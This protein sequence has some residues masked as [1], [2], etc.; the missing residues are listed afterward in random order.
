MG[1]SERLTLAL[2]LIFSCL[3]A[4]SQKTLK[5]ERKA[6]KTFYEEQF[7]KAL[8]LYQQI[9]SIDSDHSNA[10]YRLELCS[11]LI[12][13]YRTKPLNT[14]LDY[15]STQGRKDKFYNYWLGRA[16][17]TRYRYEEAIASWNAFL[18]LTV[19][20]SKIIIDETKALIEVAKN[21]NQSSQ[22]PVLFDVQKLDDHIN[23]SNSELSPTLL[24]AYNQMIF[25]SRNRS[26][27]SLKL[28]I[29][30]MSES[31]WNKPLVFDGFG[32]L[33]NENIDIDYLEPGKLF[34]KNDSKRISVITNVD[35]VWTKEPDDIKLPGGKAKSHF[36]INQDED[37]MVFAQMDYSN[38]LDLYETVKTD[39]KWSAP[40]FMVNLNTEFNEDSPFLSRDGKTLYF[41]SEG[42]D[43]VG[44][45][46][47]MVSTF[48]G[49]EWSEPQN[50]G[51]PL[52]T[53]DDELHYSSSKDG[54]YGYFSSNRLNGNGGFDIYMFKEVPFTEIEG[55]IVNANNNVFV[56]GLRI[57]FQPEKYLNQNFSNFTSNVG[58]YEMEIISSEDY[59]VR[60]FENEN[61]LLDEKLIITPEELS[62]SQI[63]RDFKVIPEGGVSLADAL[64]TNENADFN[65]D[66]Y[67]E[68][69]FIAN[70]FR[71][72]RKAMLNNLYFKSGTSELIEDSKGALDILFKVMSDNQELKVMIAGHT[73][74]KGNG[75]YNLQL[76]DERAR[77]IANEIAQKGIAPH[78][79]T[80]VGH[81]ET[82]P[83]ASNDDEKDGRALNRR[84]EVIVIE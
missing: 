62:Q 56:P 11:L 71:P 49:T 54:G 1:T 32:K 75:R 65:E 47:V 58:S 50:I 27:N 13:D 84:I 4:S 19:Y 45:F 63:R 46:D 72:G 12:E 34:I 53:I 51:Y 82:Q 7:Q 67:S 38:N 23:S 25:A 44:G 42:H 16:Y 31:G 78:R 43:A 76:S 80:P 29:T 37:R 28:F 81:G 74:S 83:L 59:N 26:D 33:S 17:I 9:L 22:D 6:D 20:K 52:N 77:M 35:G 15:S 14:I 70:K 48:D 60:I 69:D 57:E 21:A 36:S 10:K 73:D 41:S 30:T 66:G 40:A 79:M 55:V 24:P 18:A 61:L 3:S 64:A 39:D 2:I 8:P 68:L 5:L